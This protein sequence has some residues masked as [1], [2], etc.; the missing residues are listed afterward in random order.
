MMRV[1][2]HCDVCD[3]KLEVVKKITPFGEV[4]VVKTYR[5]K[6]WNTSTLFPHLCE[7]CALKIDNQ[8][9]ETKLNLLKGSVKCESRM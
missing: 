1:S 6:V 3:K 4:E 7:S 2:Y 9:L 5:T 8:L